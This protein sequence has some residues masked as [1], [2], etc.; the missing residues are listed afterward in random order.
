M[1]RLD[2]QSEQKPL[3]HLRAR[4]LRRRRLRR[5][6]QAGGDANKRLPKPRLAN[7]RVGRLE[8]LQ[9]HRLRRGGP[10]DPNPH[11]QLPVRH[12]LRRNRADLNGNAILHGQQ[13]EGRC[14]GDRRV[15][16]VERVQRLDLQ[17]E[18][19]PLRHLCASRLRRRRL[20][21]IQQAGG[22]ANERLPKPRLA[23][24]RVERMERLQRHRLRRDGP[25]D[26]NPH[27]QLSVRHRLRRNQASFVGNTI[28]LGK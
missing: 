22:D 13:S 8:R 20:R 11:R 1:Q 25:A 21:R 10:A 17:S 7:R 19:K 28:L 4:R 6:Q 16:A 5:V 3:R 14:L 26:P 23:N 9:R 24:G 12:R 27:R 15:G 18:Q 2:L